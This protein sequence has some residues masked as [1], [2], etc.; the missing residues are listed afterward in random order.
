MKGEKKNVQFFFVLKDPIFIN[1]MF[2]LIE[3]D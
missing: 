3:V 2:I 1:L